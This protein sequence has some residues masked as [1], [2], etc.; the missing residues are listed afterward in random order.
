MYLVTVVRA[1]KPIYEHAV[2]EK[3]ASKAIE[4]F[5]WPRERVTKVL[6]CERF[7][8]GIITNEDGTHALGTVTAFRMRP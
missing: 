2:D 7:Y 1:L 5:L 6:C 8:T 4:A 3:H